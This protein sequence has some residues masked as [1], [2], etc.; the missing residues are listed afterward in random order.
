MAI[1]AAAPRHGR[2]LPGRHAGR[3]DVAAPP[4]LEL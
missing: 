2:V 1:L 4:R 3:E